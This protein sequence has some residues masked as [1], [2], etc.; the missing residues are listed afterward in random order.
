MLDE[1]F[2]IKTLFINLA[3][4]GSKLSQT[5]KRGEGDAKTEGQLS[6]PSPNSHSL[7]Q[8]QTKAQPS[9]RESVSLVFRF[10]FIES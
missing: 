8:K 7:V 5:S 6:G 3:L 2:N 9:N 10:S 4:E 1:N